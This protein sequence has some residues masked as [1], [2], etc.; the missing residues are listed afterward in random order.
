MFDFFKLV[1]Q[2][3][4]IQLVTLERVMS[5]SA[6]VGRKGINKYN[7]VKIVQ[8]LLNSAIAASPPL[9]QQQSILKVDGKCGDLVIPPKNSGAQK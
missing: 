7:D 5:I 1:I 2:I 6:S 9:K 8:S 3:S 4:L